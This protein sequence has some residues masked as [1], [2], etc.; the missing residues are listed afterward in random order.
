MMLSF[1]SSVHFEDRRRALVRF[2]NTGL[3]LLAAG[4]AA[5]LG[6]AAAPR[7]G[8]NTKRWRKAASIFDLPPKTPYAAVLADRHTDGWFE[9]SKQTVVYIDRVGD[10]Y[11][12]LSATCTHLGCRVSWHEAEGAFRCPCHGGRFTRE[13]AVAGGP[14]PRPLNRLDARVEGGRVLVRVV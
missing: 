8:A 11:R 2:V 13:G 7:T 12:A 3:G 10:G 14:P 6:I 1:M 5:M 4:L 9:T